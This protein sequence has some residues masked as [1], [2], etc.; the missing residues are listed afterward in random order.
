[1]R[2]QLQQRMEA[3]VDAVAT[4]FADPAFYETLDA[5]PN[6]SRPEV[7]G[8]EATASGVRLEVRYRFTGELSA[9]V[10]AVVDPHKLSW[11]EEAN[12]DLAARTVTF[13]MLADHY[14][15]RFRCSGSYRFEALGPDATRRSCS[16]DIEIRMPLVGRR[17]ENAIVS[18]LKE[19]LDDEV[20]LVER[21]VR[22]H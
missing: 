16:G 4:A 1:M 7:L 10:R 11:I 2:F 5:L 6:L 17:V 21:W 18:G 8:H 19:H 12:H 14:A 15:D 20:A 13:R 22:G 3:P 9:A